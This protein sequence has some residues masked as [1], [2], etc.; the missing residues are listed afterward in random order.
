MAFI[1]DPE[2]TSKSHPD[3][4]LSMSVTRNPNACIPTESNCKRLTVRPVLVTDD[5]QGAQPS[6]LPPRPRNDF[7]DP[8]DI[9]GARPKPLHYERH[10]KPDFTTTNKDIEGK[11][12]SSTSVYSG[13]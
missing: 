13:S 1:L 3:R 9:E 11:C 12:S 2:A 10:N 4:F 5:I 8:S 7:H 6:V